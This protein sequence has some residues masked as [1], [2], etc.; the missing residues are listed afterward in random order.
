YDVWRFDVTK[1]STKYAYWGSGNGKTDGWANGKSG[2]SPLGY[3]I[4][5]FLTPDYDKNAGT[6][7]SKRNSPIF[8]LAE[9]YMI[10]AEAM[11][12]YLDIPDAR[13]YDYI[14]KVRGRVKMPSLPILAADQTKEGMRKR[15]QNEDR[16]EFAFET[17]R[18]WDI[19]RWMLGTVVNNGPVHVLNAKPSVAELTASGISDINS[20][21]AGVAVFYK[22]VVIQN[23]VF[24]DKHYLMP[25]PQSEI[26]KDPDLVQN[27]GW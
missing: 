1:R 7:T 14:N 11:N 12:E 10:Y 18:L 19:R 15:I 27:Y 21:Q 9:M 4:R 25:V 6:G 3:N 17:H 20:E 26:D 16:V 23:R 5:K 13:V 22:P 24:Q 8:R 2:T